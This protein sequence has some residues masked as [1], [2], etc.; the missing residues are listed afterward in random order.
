MNRRRVLL[1]CAAVLLA[2]AVSLVF[3]Q[4]KDRGAPGPYRVVIIENVDQM[5]ATQDKFRDS[6]YA[7]EAINNL[8]AEG[9][10]VVSMSVLRTNQ[11]IVIVR[12]P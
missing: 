11:I 6:V 1:A 9:Y 8:H 5:T 3:A 2:G 4:G 12:K 10:E 7:T